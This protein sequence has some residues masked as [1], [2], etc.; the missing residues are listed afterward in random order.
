MVK[1]GSVSVLSSQCVCVCVYV[2]V[3]ECMCLCVRAC[4]RTVCMHVTYVAVV[5]YM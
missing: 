2:C 1:C 5:Q 3:H 4:V